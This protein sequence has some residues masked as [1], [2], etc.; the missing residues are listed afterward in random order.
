[1]NG[2]DTRGFSYVLEPVRCQRQWKFDAALAWVGKLYQQLCDK[3]AARLAIHEECTAQAAQVSRAWAARPD[4]LAQA[5]VLNYLAALHRR[6]EDAE[7]ELAVL[8]ETLRRARKECA[9]EQQALEVLDQHR[10]ELSQ[11]YAGEQL[12]K[13]S[14]QADQDWAARTSHGLA[15]EEGR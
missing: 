14:A 4:P 2:A 13:F 12:R 8:A 3:D 6:R 9:G 10:A 11:A 15:E 7:R 5:R 1:M